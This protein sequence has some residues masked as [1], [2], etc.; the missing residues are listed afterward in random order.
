MVEKRFNEFK[1]STYP[2]V[3]YYENLGKLI[4]VNGEDLPENIFKFINM[5]IDK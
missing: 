4:R 2:V 1:K 5:K 3:E